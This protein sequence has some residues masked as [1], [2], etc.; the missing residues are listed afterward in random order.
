MSLL[1]KFK[2]EGYIQLEN[3]L[4]SSESIKKC[5]KDFLNRENDYKT[6]Y[7]QKHF[8]YGFDGYSY[9]GQ[10]DSS[11]QYDDDMLYSFVIKL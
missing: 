5:F 6:N 10:E 8:N 4:F 7:L 11:N 9:M 1:E 2:S 3:P